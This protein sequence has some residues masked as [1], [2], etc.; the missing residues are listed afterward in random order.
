V[1]SKPFTLKD[2]AARAGVH[3]STVS[4]VM[5]PE[6][7]HLVGDEVAARVLQS[8]K[9]MGYRPNQSAVA[10]RTR[11]SNTIG[12]VLPD[13]TNPVFPPILRG[14]EEE[15]RKAR[16]VALVGD[17]QSDDDQYHVVQQMLARQVDGLILATT[18]RRDP[19][20][21]HCLENSVPVV[22]VNRGEDVGRSSSVVHDEDAG[23]RLAVQHLVELGHR[24]IGHIPGPQHLST[25]HLRK[26]GF[27]DAMALAGIKP[28][29]YEIGEESAYSR[30]GGR[31]ALIALLK[32][33]P[34]LT[35]VVA[36]NDLVALGCYE[37]LEEL[38]IRCPKDLSIVGHNDMPFVDLVA[39]PLTTVRISH[40]EMGAHAA[41]LI[42]QRIGGEDNSVVDIHLKPEL[43]I[44]KSTAP[45][46]RAR[47]V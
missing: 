32:K 21:D 25:G 20:I 23:M 26:R 14:I 3:A 33:R 1:S 11:K 40:H 2:V 41:R 34:Q 38:K 31:R 7:R 4:R 46:R 44:R 45:P 13:I 30:D 27:V 42:L 28:N 6:T 9:L 18:T 22:S 43:V 47:R 35:A 17:A 5:N 39:P 8:A 15:L 36:A 37:A 19:I 24:R 12:V 29:E 16:Y 10:L